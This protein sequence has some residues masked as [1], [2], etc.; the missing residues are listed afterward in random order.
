MWSGAAAP[1]RLHDTAEGLVRA[2]GVVVLMAIIVV[3]FAV[4]V[5]LRG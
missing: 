4:G 3:G 1:G 2:L 5:E